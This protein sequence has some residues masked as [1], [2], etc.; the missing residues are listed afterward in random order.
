M[1]GL[2]FEGD[3]VNFKRTKSAMSCFELEELSEG[4]GTLSFDSPLEDRSPLPGAEE[5]PGRGGV[6]C[7]STSARGGRRQRQMAGAIMRA[8]VLGSDPANVMLT[9]MVLLPSLSTDLLIPHCPLW[10]GPLD[11]ET[12]GL[13]VTL[14]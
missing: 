12:R 7:L 9:I 2:C 1:E 4:E 13:S 6:S 3:V 5:W 11:P 8:P 14:I 10:R